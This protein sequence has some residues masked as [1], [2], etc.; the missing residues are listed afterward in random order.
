M[1]RVPMRPTLTAGVQSAAQPL[2]GACLVL[3]VPECLEC[4]VI[5]VQRSP[6]RLHRHREDVIGERQAPLGRNG[7]IGDEGGRAR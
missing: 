3:V 4:L 7:C 1:R 2:Q 5:G 6:K